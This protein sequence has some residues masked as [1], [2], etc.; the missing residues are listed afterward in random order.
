MRKVLFAMVLLTAFSIIAHAQT[1]TPSPSVTATAAK[2]E[3]KTESKR[4]PV[5]R[6]SKEQIT[7]A[8]SI[9]KQKGLFSGEA[10]GKL[11]DDTR[12]SLKTFQNNEKIRA[13][14]TL[15]RI[16]LEKLGV[17]LTDTQKSIPV[18]E[19]SLTPETAPT[20]KTRKASFRAVRDQILQAQKILKG[21]GMYGGEQSGKMSDDFRA[22]VRK[23]QESEK[24]AVTGTLNRETIEK[25]A[26]PLTDKQKE[27]VAAVTSTK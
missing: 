25:L 8:Q 24:I 22:A 21:K 19:S 18:T 15:N 3:V 26:I 6:A 14:G 10:T 23:Y 1:A 13:A 9:L 17:S 12:A 27:N 7:Q 20:G 16:T 11:D 5:F 4:S 2:T